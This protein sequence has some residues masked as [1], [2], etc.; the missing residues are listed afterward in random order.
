[1][2]VVRRTA[3]RILLTDAGSFVTLVNLDRL[4]NPHVRQQYDL[5][6]LRRAAADMTRVVTGGAGPHEAVWLGYLF[7]TCMWTVGE[8]TRGASWRGS[9][10][11]PG[12]VGF[13]HG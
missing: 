9:G 2:H 1:M 6:A 10:P 13:I 4:G 5:R 8:G 7:I 12:G 11:V 3:G